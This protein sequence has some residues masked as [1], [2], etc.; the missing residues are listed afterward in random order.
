MKVA[1]LVPNDVLADS[2]VRRQVRTLTAAGMTVDTYGLAVGGYR[3]DYPRSIEGCRKL[4]IT[5]VSQLSAHPVLRNVGPRASVR[6]TGFEN[7]VRWIMDRLTAAVMPIAKNLRHRQLAHFIVKS[8]GDETYDVIH[9]H[10]VVA[11]I[12]GAKMKKLQPRAKIVWDAHEVY[13]DLASSDRRSGA[14]TRKLIKRCERCVDAF[15]TINDSIARFYQKHY[16]LPKAAVIMNATTHAGPVHNDGRLRRAAGLSLNRKIMIFQGGLS[17]KR[18]LTVLAEAAFDL[19]EP[20]SIVIMGWGPLETHLRQIAE[21]VNLGRAPGSERIAFVE[22]APQEELVH[23]TAGADLG[24]IPYEDHGLNHRYCTP[25]KLWEFPNAGVPIVATALDE[26]EAMISAWGTGFLMPR[27]IRPLDIVEL[28][29]GL[30]HDRIL[31][32]RRNCARFASE[33]AWSRFEPALLEIYKS[34]GW[35]SARIGDEPA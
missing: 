23:L 5:Q 20:W 8:I 35:G 22:A 11:L 4:V 15:V 32:A 6:R 25:N 16:R 24:I 7:F 13:E 1:V 19:P 29:E 18:G 21:K 34:F 28:L 33:M 27:N 10:D 26:M 30:K 31:E 12:A 3:K 17:P 14:N 2:R 9:C